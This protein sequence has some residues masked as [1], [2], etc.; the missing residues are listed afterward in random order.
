VGT[1][2]Y[3]TLQDD[4]VSPDRSNDALHLLLRHQPIW[5][6]EDDGLALIE[7]GLDIPTHPQEI[8]GEWVFLFW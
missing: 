5:R 2:G 7:P 3:K 1:F 4:D 8:S 6:A